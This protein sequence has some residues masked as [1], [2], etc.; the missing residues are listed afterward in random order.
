[1]AGWDKL[2]R[3]ALNEARKAKKRAQSDARARER[4]DLPL[5]FITIAALALVGAGSATLAFWM[6]RTGFADPP[7]LNAAPDDRI[8][9][10]FYTNTAPI[11]DATLREDRPIALI[12]RADGQV[13][14]YNLQTGLFAD[15]ARAI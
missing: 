2:R 15:S 3:A 4:I 13:H 1:M 11:I 6:D 10:N 9:E 5:I 12:G 8:L 14:G 7:V